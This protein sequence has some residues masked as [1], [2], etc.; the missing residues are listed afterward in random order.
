MKPLYALCAETC[1]NQT[2]IDEFIRNNDG[3]NADPPTVDKYLAKVLITE[4]V[5]GKGYLKPENARAIRIILELESQLRNSLLGMKS[6]STDESKHPPGRNKK[7]IFF[8][9]YIYS[10][11]SWLRE[12]KSKRDS[13]GKIKAAHHLSSALYFF[14]VL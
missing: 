3:L 14:L 2:A 8:F 5:F 13:I 6:N 7:L 10:V 12:I 9:L 1:K 11:K 4:L